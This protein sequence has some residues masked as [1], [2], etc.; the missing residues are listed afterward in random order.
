MFTYS[1]TINVSPFKRLCDGSQYA[2]L[3]LSD[4]ECI[5]QS[6]LNQV[7][8][9]TRG[10][11]GMWVYEPTK[12]GHPHL[13]TLFKVD[14]ELSK[15]QLLDIRALSNRFGNDL[16][17]KAIFIAKCADDGTSWINYMCKVQTP[18]KIQE[19]KNFKIGHKTGKFIFN[20]RK[21]LNDFIDRQANGEELSIEFD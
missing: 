19:I 12:R 21:A 7:K 20:S 9:I 4:Q 18:E 1:V 6:I 2:K 17:N 10:D 16:F 3:C 14:R 11:F 5:L 8:D 13:H 15:G